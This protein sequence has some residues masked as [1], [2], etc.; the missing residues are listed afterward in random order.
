MSTTAR[1][2][3]KRERHHLLNVAARYRA[4]GEPNGAREYQD[5]ADALAWTKPAK[6][7]T[8]LLRRA[9]FWGLPLRW[10]LSAIA[11][12]GQVISTEQMK[13]L[14]DVDADRRRIARRNRR[15]SS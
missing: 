12:R 11:A 6:V 14:V 13:Q 4:S 3:R 7:A 10:Q 8:P 15:R 1:K 9:R 5:R 2:A